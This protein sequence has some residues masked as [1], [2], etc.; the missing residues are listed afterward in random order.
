MSA[1]SQ[2]LQTTSD[3]QQIGAYQL[4][5]LLGEGSSTRIW[6]A[7]QLSPVVR[8][9]AL[10]VLKVGMDS[11][12]A[13]Q[14][15]Q[16]EQ[17]S[18]AQMDHPGIAR[19][20]DAGCTPSGQPYFVMECVA[21]GLP[22]TEHGEK[23]QLNLPQRLA[24]FLSLC[25]AVQHAHQKGVIHRDLKPSN[26][27]VS[28]GQVKVIDFGIAKTSSRDF[29]L[30]QMML[31]GTTGYMSP[32]QMLDPKEVDVR[33]DIFALG[34]LLQE[35]TRGVPQARDVV[36]IIRRCLE[37]DRTRRYPSAS[38]LADDVQRYLDHRPI[39]ARPPTL[40]YTTLQLVRRHRV[41]TLGIVTALLMLSLGTAV[42]LHQANVAEQKQRQSD[43]MTEVLVAAWMNTASDQRVN[44]TLISALRLVK[45]KICD[46]RFIGRPE[47]CCRVLLEVSEAAYAQM[48]YQLAHEA[49]Q[50]TQA[51]L[52]ELQEVDPPLQMRTWLCLGN[53]QVYDQSAAKAIPAL[54]QAWRLGESHFG[55]LA[56]ATITAQRSL[57]GAMVLAKDPAAAEMLRDTLNKGRERQLPQDHFDMLTASLDLA[58]ITFHEGKHQEALQLIDQ[59]LTDARAGGAIKRN[60]IVRILLRKG[61]LLANAKQHAQ[62]IP[63][64]EDAE[65]EA[66]QA[67]LPDTAMVILLRY[68]RG[69]S[70]LSLKRYA[71]A[72]ELLSQ[73]FDDQ[74][75]YYGI[76]KRQPRT[77]AMHLA[78][79]Y[80]QMKNW[81]ALESLLTQVLNSVSADFHYPY[82][83]AHI[84][85]L[86]NHHQSLGHQEQAQAWQKRLSKKREAQTPV[87]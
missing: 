44:P 15:F 54:R 2:H 60:L 37:P 11:I 55:P 63:A 67:S 3:V 36:W 49:A 38:A 6:K 51:L 29:D 7:R 77:T 18:L 75:R 12:E 48:E 83:D 74:V 62:A 4:L 35:I 81:Q 82:H 25:L 50:D 86:V 65:R 46:K 9:V 73:V 17:E 59:T 68:N 34:V 5:H 58:T 84:Q 45:S 79:T 22:I 41:L 32:E 28:Q 19:V 31:L 14:R 33:T 64:Y 23:H 8:E 42:A 27:L 78:T 10:K 39:T 1:E 76:R 71:E 21:E 43:A 40:A 13:L 30:T 20:W 66:K 26:V 69:L 80:L 70:L 72:A 53:A 52:Q 56:D 16:V 61:T 47:V 57:G 87:E 24:L 85:A